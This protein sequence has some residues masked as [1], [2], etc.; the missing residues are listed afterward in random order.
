MPAWL[1]QILM[2]AGVFTVLGSI[3]RGVSIWPK[4]RGEGNQAEAG[5]VEVLTKAQI[6]R[7]VDALKSAEDET[8][9]AKNACDA[10]ERKLSA[11]ERRLA[12][13]DEATDALIDAILEF[14][15]LIPNVDATATAPVRAAITTARRARHNFE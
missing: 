8:K 12:A 14:L 3:V 11:V 4:T 2:S 10:C 13:R 15:P 9:R 5:A 7:Q 1:Q 6:A